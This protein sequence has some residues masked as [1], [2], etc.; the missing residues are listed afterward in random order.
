[1]TLEAY[2]WL[3]ILLGFASGAILGLFFR[4][5]EWLGGYGSFRRRVL[6]LG[7]VALVGLG[8]LNILAHGSLSRVR[9]EAW[10]L[11]VAR[12]G[13]I[14]GGVAMPLVCGLTAWKPAFGKLFFIPVAC[15]VTAAVTLVRGL[16]A[17]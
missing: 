11:D 9:L 13:F 4:R 3:L 6:R 8:I 15:L 7:H 16:L 12:W 1:M 14:A 10:E 2:G 17:A 5:E